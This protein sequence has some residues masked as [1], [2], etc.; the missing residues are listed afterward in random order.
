VIGF[1]D[2]KLS[3]LAARTGAIQ[4]RAMG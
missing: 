3:E 4:T 1:T 2:M